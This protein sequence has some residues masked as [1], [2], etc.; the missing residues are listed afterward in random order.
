MLV[1]TADLSLL[2]AELIR[3]MWI[4]ELNCDEQLIQVEQVEF[5]KL[6]ANTTAETGGL[7]PDMWELAWPANYPDAHNLLSD[8]LHC[9]DGENRQNRPCSDA[10]RLM[11]RAR[12]T[13]D[14]MERIALYRQVENE[15]FSENG[16][17][18]LIPLYVRGDYMLVQG[19]LD[20]PAAL[21]GGEQFDTYRIDQEL[22]RLERSRS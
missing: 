2:Q 4:S 3:D 21:S 7:R 22:K 10:D 17:F 13:A 14:P 16:N 5:G 20:F 18:P 8:L 15:F 11:H 6:L 9:T 19:W 1:S 12:T